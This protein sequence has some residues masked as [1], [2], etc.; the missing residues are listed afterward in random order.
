MCAFQHETGNLY[1][2]NAILTEEEKQFESYV[3]TKFRKVFDYFLENQK[4]FPC[5]FCDYTP[6]SK[7]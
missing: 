4:N 1:D 2:Q 6:K 3:E 5:Y 7:K